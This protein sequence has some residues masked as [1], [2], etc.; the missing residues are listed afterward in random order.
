MTT[1]NASSA[2]PPWAVTAIV[3]AAL[4]LARLARRHVPLAAPPRHV[5]SARRLATR[6]RRVGGLMRPR[7]D[8]SALSPRAA[9]VPIGLS[10]LDFAKRECGIGMMIDPTGDIAADM[11]IIRGYY[12]GILGRH[13]H[14]QCVPRL[15]EEDAP[16]AEQKLAM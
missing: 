11:K 13:P 8:A 2:L 14:L 5:L 7:I 6:L 16:P 1:S 15:R 4:G 12:A 3:G 9:H 10:S